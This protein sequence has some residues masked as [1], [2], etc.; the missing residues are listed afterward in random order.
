MESLSNREKSSGMH[1]SEIVRVECRSEKLKG[2]QA[3]W[4]DPR[5]NPGDTRNVFC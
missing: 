5:K 2:G 4:S 1:S 3:M